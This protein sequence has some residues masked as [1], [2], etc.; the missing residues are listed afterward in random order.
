M[1]NRQSRRRRGTT[2]APRTLPHSG[3]QTG[4]RLDVRVRG[5][6]H[7]LHEKY[8]QMA[9]DAQQS[10]DRVACEYYLQ[11]ADHY[12]RILNDVRQHQDEGRQRRVNLK[13]VREDAEEDIVADEIEDER[14]GNERGDRTGED[15]SAPRARTRRPLRRPVR[16]R[17]NAEGARE[18]D[19][20]DG[21]LSAGG[22]SDGE[23]ALAAFG[24]VAA[25]APE[26]R[27]GA[28]P[29]VLDLGGDP[30]AEA[31]PDA[32]EA[33]AVA[34]PVRRRRTRKSADAADADKPAVRAESPAVAEG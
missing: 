17:G 24:G 21:G 18:G 3:S 5:N 12:F 9:R 29:L 8:K 25:R 28:Q 26:P 11:Y 22:L 2:S 19:P 4:N 32:G 23:A 13:A 10:G 27:P 7:Q 1:Q 6:A 34:K 30:L 14:I 15:D 33:A 16:S 20:A 31:A